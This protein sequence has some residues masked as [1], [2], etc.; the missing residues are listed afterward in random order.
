E[1]GTTSD[2]VFEKKKGNRAREGVVYKKQS[3][4]GHH[5]AGSTRAAAIPPLF[6]EDVSPRSVSRGDRSRRICRFFLG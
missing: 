6:A 4:P 5:I 3:G 2:S 1:E